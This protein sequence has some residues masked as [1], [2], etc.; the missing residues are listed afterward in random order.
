MN[1]FRTK[2]KEGAPPQDDRTAISQ[3]IEANRQAVQ[4]A[5]TELQRLS[6]QA[7][8][9]DDNRAAIAAFDHLHKLHDQQRL[10]EAA[11]C[12]AERIEQERQ[13]EFKSGQTPCRAR[14]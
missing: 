2:P 7:V 13:A 3:K 5:Q 10:L 11:L 6:L 14:G 1:F 12:E 8:H 9:D 4:A